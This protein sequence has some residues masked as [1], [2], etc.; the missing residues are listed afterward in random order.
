M[1]L[2]RLRLSSYSRDFVIAH[3]W[4]VVC[5]KSKIVLACVIHVMNVSHLV[6]SSR[7]A[8]TT[9]RSFS[10]RTSRSFGETP[11]GR[12]GEEGG[13]EVGGSRFKDTCEL[14]GFGFWV[15]VLGF[16]GSTTNRCQNRFFPW[17]EGVGAKVDF[18]CREEG[19]RVHRLLLGETFD[20]LVIH[21][22]FDH[23]KL[24]VHWIQSS[25]SLSFHFSIRLAHRFWTL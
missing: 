19:E 3:P 8:R 13:L 7:V 11:K 20:V 4:I 18:F 5:I 6:M 1:T 24:L 2:H 22:F 23:A 16:R 14:K 10:T 9:R 21:G 17:E 25:V 12:W 15:Y